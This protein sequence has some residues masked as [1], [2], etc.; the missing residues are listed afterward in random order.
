MTAVKKNTVFIVGERVN[1]TP[2]PIVDSK[3][4]EEAKKEYERLQKGEKEDPVLKCT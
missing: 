3:L 4:L 1:T 2:I